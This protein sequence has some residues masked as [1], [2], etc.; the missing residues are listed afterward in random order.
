MTPTVKSHKIITIATGVSARHDGH[1]VG[2]NRDLVGHFSRVGRGGLGM[3]S[4]CPKLASGSGRSASH[5]AVAPS[6]RGNFP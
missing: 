2:R 5:L 3:V 1:D 4:S 6:P